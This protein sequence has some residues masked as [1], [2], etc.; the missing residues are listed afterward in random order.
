[1]QTSTLQSC[2]P[3]PKT[4]ESTPAQVQQNDSALIGHW[5][6]DEGNGL[7]ATSVTPEKSTI[8]LDGVQWEPRTPPIIALYLVVDA[9]ARFEE[10]F[11][12]DFDTT[13]LTFAAWIATE[14]DGSIFSEALEEPECGCPTAK[15]FLSE[16]DN[17]L[18]M[19]VGSV[20]SAVGTGEVRNQS[21]TA[22]WHHVG[23]TLATSNGYR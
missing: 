7:H 2:F 23:L 13:D 15:P 22:F 9:E 20:S 12:L 11:A 6:F 16:M 5:R 1:M 14:D 21:L 19:S 4:S 8:V 18:L 3:I 17:W 10:D